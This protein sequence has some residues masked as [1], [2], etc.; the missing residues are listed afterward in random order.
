MQDITSH[1]N[2]AMAQ[3]VLWSVS[4]FFAAI[5]QLESSEYQVSFWKDEENWAG[6]SLG[7]ERRDIAC[8]WRRYPLIMI[9]V[10]HST[11]IRSLLKDYPYIVYISV[12]S[13]DDQSLRVEY[14]K[15]V[16]PYG[17]NRHCFS[18]VDLWFHTVT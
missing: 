10:D 6:V 4:E 13:L 1:I 15:D 9:T 17:L 3:Q 14:I 11:N 16:T 7:R 12:G 2:A 18:A 5:E 8:I